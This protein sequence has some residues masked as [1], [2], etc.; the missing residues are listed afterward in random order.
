MCVVIVF[1]PCRRGVLYLFAVYCPNLRRVSTFVYVVTMPYEW[2]HTV[3][4]IRPLHTRAHTHARIIYIYIIA[5]YSLQLYLCS[6]GFVRHVRQDHNQWSYIFF[7]IHLRETREIDHT[8]LERYIRICVSIPTPV[9]LIV[10]VRACQGPV[11]T[12]NLGPVPDLHL[13]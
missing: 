11:R 12:Y 5:L 1:R 10:S 13:D 3:F 6:Q 4:R 2:N 8:A 9:F 7:L